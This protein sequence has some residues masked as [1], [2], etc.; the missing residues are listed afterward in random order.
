VGGAG[1]E[2]QR[3]V[4]DSEKLERPMSS[5]GLWWADDDGLLTGLLALPSK[6]VLIGSVFRRVK[7]CLL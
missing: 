2:R 5:S 3:V 1:C 4:R 7:P 6:C